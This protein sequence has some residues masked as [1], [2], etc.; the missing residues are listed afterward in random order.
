MF[1]LSLITLG[2]S[3]ERSFDSVQSIMFLDIFFL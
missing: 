1:T 3:I 2:K